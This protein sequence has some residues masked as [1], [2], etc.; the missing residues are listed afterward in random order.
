[1]SG[2]SIL[3]LILGF[4]LIFNV[5]GYNLNTI[6]VSAV[7]NM[8]DY[9]DEMV[10][11]NIAMTGANMGANKLFLDNTW[12]AGISINSIYDGTMN[13]SVETIDEFEDVRLVTSVGTYDGVTK[14]VRLTV[15]PSKFS[16]FAYF[17]ENEPNW[18]WWMEEDTVWG[19]MHVNSDLHCRDNPT[20]MGK[21]TISGEIDLYDEGHEPNLNGG[22][23]DGVEMR[24]PQNGIA[25]LKAR[26][27]AGGH[28]FTGHD[29][30]LLDFD[31]QN[32]KYKFSGGDDY[33]VVNAAIFAPNGVIFAD[34]MDI[35]LK[36]GV[37]DGKFTIAASKESSGNDGGTIWLFGDIEY[38]SD[39]LTNP[40]S[41][42]ML[43]ICAEVDV[44]IKDNNNNS[45]DIVI[46]ASIY[47]ETGGFG[48][49]DHNTRGVSGSIYLTGGITQM[50]RRP[51]G[52]FNHLGQLN[53]GFRKKYK[54][55]ERMMN[56]SPP[57]FPGTGGFEMVSWFQ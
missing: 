53:N 6:S 34:E 36:P 55:D 17:C 38:A 11:K 45:N 47:A 30:V 43:G 56:S 5:I 18:I 39:P 57:G 52:T 3:P 19:P 23:Q 22:F 29:K 12:N 8:V 31:G 42:D 32:L 21:V 4:T 10:A 49:E 9:Y 26:A 37:V 16:K 15:K 28:V 7:D 20:F 35:K 46:H 48:A 33:I 41:D 27:E 44:L 40:D 24:I 2:R 25:D 13:V 14:E 54:Y 1:M 50:E 51:V